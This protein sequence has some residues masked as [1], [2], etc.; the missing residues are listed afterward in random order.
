M[1]VAGVRRHHDKAILAACRA[2]HGAH[3]RRGPLRCV[4]EC[5]FDVLN[6]ESEP[7]DPRL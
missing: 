1:L 7:V 6:L 5:V 2:S 3:V 4:H